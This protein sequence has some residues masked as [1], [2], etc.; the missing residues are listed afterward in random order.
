[1]GKCTFENFLMDEH[2][3][4]Y[5]GYGDDICEAFEE[6]IQNI[7]V[8]KWLEFGDKFAKQ[9]S[10]ELLEACKIALDQH[11]RKYPQCNSCLECK[12]LTEAIAKTEVL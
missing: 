7:D 9:Q 6:W 4:D 12:K 10:K 1:M 5:T 11:N 8:D 3:R 2:A